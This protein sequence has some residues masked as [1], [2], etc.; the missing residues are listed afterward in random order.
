MTSKAKGRRPRRAF[1]LPPSSAAADGGCD[2]F[3][4][5]S[6]LADL[7]TAAGLPYALT[8][9][10]ARTEANALNEEFNDFVIWDEVSRR[11]AP[12]AA[13]ADWCRHVA[14]RAGELQRGLG[15]QPP[16]VG[17][18]GQPFR[19]AM[20]HL[21][22][23][24]LQ[25]DHLARSALERA[26]REEFTRQLAEGA[27]S[28]VGLFWS[29]MERLSFTLSALARIAAAAADGWAAEV[30][31]GG[32][33][34]NAARRLLFCALGAS[35]ERMFG[36]PPTVIYK[37]TNQASGRETEPAG[38]ALEWHRA[39][40]C[41]VRDRARAPTVPMGGG[42]PVAPA[43][44]WPGAARLAELGDWAEGV[45]QGQPTGKSDG[46]AAAIKGAIALRRSHAD[47]MR[48]TADE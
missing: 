44:V 28:G 36:T 25:D 39:V 41:L 22:R 10:A 11:D 14:E 16:R 35:Y 40:L 1:N 33:E 3:L 19:D 46:L 5:P 6:D 45:R 26:E 13:K 8:H 29:A 32:R 47:G 18:G 17:A 7:A 2:V 9:D 15:M 38:P 43:E 48:N 21:A 30:K 42:P 12:E 31:T 23:G 20:S 24:N 4:L 27:P 34:P 37:L